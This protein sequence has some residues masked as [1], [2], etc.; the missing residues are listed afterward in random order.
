MPNLRYQGTAV[1]VALTM[2]ALSACTN[3]F[4]D[5]PRD[6]ELTFYNDSDNP[7]LFLSGH[8][9]QTLQDVLD[10]REYVGLV[11]AP[12]GA[13]WRRSFDTSPRP[14]DHEPWCVNRQYWILRSRSGRSYHADPGVEDPPIELEDLEIL[15]YLGPDHCWPE[16]V[17]E[18]HYPTD[19]QN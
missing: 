16:R 5:E 12:P 2:M 15:A 14:G 8:P 13:V 6:G 19:T 11:S 4:S 10:S 3:P 1:A 18:F 9:S 7:V 17:T